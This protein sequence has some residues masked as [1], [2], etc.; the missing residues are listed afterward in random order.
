MPGS[1]GGIL[2]RARY[3]D[4]SLVTKLNSG[5]DQVVVLGAG[6]D[7][8]AYRLPGIEKTRVFEVDLPGTME[9]KAKRLSK[10]LGQI[11]EHVVLVG[12]DFDQ[13]ELGDVLY[14]A[15]FQDGRRT[16][17][18]W[19]GVTQYLTKEAV[20]DTLTFVADSSGKGSG[21]V[22]TYIRKDLFQGVDTPDWFQGYLDFAAR[23]GSPVGFGLAPDQ[24]GDYLAGLGLFLVSD[25]GAVEYKE[26]Y[27][28]PIGRKLST[29]DIERA[30]YAEVESS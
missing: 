10:V 26:W 15:S 22:F 24:L 16:F 14:Q 25:V 20:R 23:V 11:P 30:A 28:D 29:F 1:L 7:T 27:L 17:F 6:F 12:I 4:D 9:L 5:L 19:E 2:L 3:I 21:I 18:I 8:R 13:Q